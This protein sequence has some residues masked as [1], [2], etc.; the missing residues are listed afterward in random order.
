MRYCG[1]DM[2]FPK[3]KP[4]RSEK[5]LDYIRAMPCLRCGKPGPC[6][7]HHVSVKNQG[8]GT[9]PPDYQAVPLCSGLSGC[10]VKEESQPTWGAEDYFPWIIRFMGRWIQEKL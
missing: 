9:K 3:N 7:P 1:L 10:H 5:Y 6:D 4:W 8:W 2:Q